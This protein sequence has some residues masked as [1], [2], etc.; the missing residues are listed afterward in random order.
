MLSSVMTNNKPNFVLS[1]NNGK[2]SDNLS[3]KGLTRDMERRIYRNVDAMQKIYYANKGTTAGKPPSDITRAIIDVSDSKIE[4]GRNIA[5]FM[6]S[7]NEAVFELKQYEELSLK[8]ILNFDFQACFDEEIEKSNGMPNVADVIAKIP[9]CVSDEEAEVIEKHAAY[10]IEKTLKNSGVLPEDGK[11]VIEFLGS[12]EYGNAFKLSFRDENGEKIFHDKVIKVYKSEEAQNE[13]M[14][15]II[16]NQIEYFKNTSFDEYWDTVLKE[17]QAAKNNLNFEWAPESIEAQ[18]SMMREQFDKMRNGTVDELLKEYNEANAFKKDIHGCFAEANRALFIKDRIGNLRETN[19]I[20]P[21]YFDFENKYAVMEM[22]DNE[23]P[24]VK[25]E[26][27]LREKLH[28]IPGDA[29]LNPNNKVC[30][31]I[32]DYGGIFPAYTL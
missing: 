8:A 25:K 22:S 9:L 17:I 24:E 19:C 32:I 16:R 5:D 4:A 6:S 2:V 31:R 23:L 10:P 30:G 27:D 26:I 18:K 1:Q 7:L 21:Y 28:L 13:F 15:P 20:E 14:K 29:V 11:V 12:G 3:F